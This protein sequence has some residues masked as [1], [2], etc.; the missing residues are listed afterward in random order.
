MHPRVAEEWEDLSSAYRSVTHA[1]NPERIEVMIDL[2][3][4][5]YSAAQT[6]VAVLIPSG[7]RATPLDGFLVPVSLRFADGTA[8][9]GGD[10]GGAGAPGWFL[11]SFH[12]VDEQGASTWRGTADAT[13]GDN[14]VGYLQSIECFLA[15][16]C[17]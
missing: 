17:N 14:L 4:G 15:R 6:A 9:P 7:Y 3:D 10:A 11:V 16:G 1:D 8:L 12:L 13:R 5:T 2:A